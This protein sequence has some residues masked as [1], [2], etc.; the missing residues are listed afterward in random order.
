MFIPDGIIALTTDFQADSFYVA[1]MK[2]S[3]Y[4]IARE[5][6]LVDVTHSISPQN[7]SQASWVLLRAIEAFPQGTVHVVVVDPGVGTPRKIIAVMLQGQVIIGPDNGLFDVVASRYPV[8]AVFEINNPVY[9]GEK[10]SSTFHGRDI[11]VPAAAH[12]VRGVPLESLGDRRDVSLIT[13]EK[14][15]ALLAAREG[16][17]IHG[18]F[19]YADS[20]GNLVTN[21]FAHD[22][23]EDWDP[24]SIRIEAAGQIVSGIVSTYGE[25]EPGELVALFGSSG[26]LELSIVQGDAAQKYGVGGGTPVKIMHDF[27]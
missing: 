11:M 3:A 6:R 7:V 26:Q 24:Q 18:R 12:L 4:I 8:E 25:R 22:I 21:V 13:Q 19:V 23:P 1:E 10:W 2:A 17:E 5:A 20:F 15:A 9:F 14:T 27:T 16:Q